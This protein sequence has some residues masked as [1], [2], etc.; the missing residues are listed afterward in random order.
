MGNLQGGFSGALS[1]DA[2]RTA[3]DDVLYEEFSRE[4]QPGDVSAQNGAYFKE[5]PTVGISFIH[6]EDRGVGDFESIGEQEELL[7]SSTD[8]GNQVTK[9][10]V[11]FY[12]Q[13]PISDEAFRA[14]MVGKRE[15]IGRS[16]GRRGR[17][18]QTKRAIL[19]TYGD[20]F[21]GAVNTTPDGQAPASNSHVSLSG[22]TVDNLETA[23]LSPD[24]LWTTVQS[25]ANQRAQDGD[26]GSHL[27][28]R[29]LSNFNLYKTAKEVMASA[30]IADS[31][32]NN[33]NIFDT[34]YGEVAIAASIYLNTAYNSA[35][36]AATSYHL[37]SSDHQ[38]LRKVFYGMTT[39][40]KT[41]HETTNDTY[42]E[43]AKFHE[44]PFF[45]TWTGYVGNNGSA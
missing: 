27:F 11:K 16:I 5:G 6:D 2:V 8:I 22:G 25:L 28:E 40:L 3:I 20:A 9:N 45:G 13:V 32:E 37:M 31:G 10:S 18:T 4:R 34:D 29:F 1:P 44:V 35:T 23:A 39:D 36:N 17:T 26:D 15:A 7:N 33:I 38:V 41:P 21:A 42:A 19:D 12:K 14:D 30:L 43:V 24:G